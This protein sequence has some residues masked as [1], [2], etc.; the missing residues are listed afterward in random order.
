M[1][2][3]LKLGPV[4]AALAK[5]VEDSLRLTQQSSGLHFGPYLRYCLSRLKCQFEILNISCETMGLSSFPFPLV[6]CEAK[7]S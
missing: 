4:S 3:A 6:V 7:T 5:A 1:A 2:E